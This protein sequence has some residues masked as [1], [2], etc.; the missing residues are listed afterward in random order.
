[1]VLLSSIISVVDFCPEIPLPL[2]TPHD[3]AA[4]SDDDHRHA[5]NDDSNGDGERGVWRQVERLAKVTHLAILTRAV[6][7]AALPAHSKYLSKQAQG[8]VSLPPLPPLFLS[9][10]VAAARLE[11]IPTSQIR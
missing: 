7:T 10:S 8:C 9:P 3:C 6:A 1:M 11:A 4:E 2:P 5:E